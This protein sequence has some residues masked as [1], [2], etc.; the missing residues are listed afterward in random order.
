MDKLEKFFKVKESGSTVRTEIVAGITTFFAMAYIVLVAPN[1]LT[2]FSTEYQAVWNS[3][4]IAS[5]LVAV[6]GTL[7]MAFHAKMPYAQACGMGLLSV[8]SVC[9]MMPQIISGGNVEAGYQAGLVIVFLSGV[10]FLIMTVT[11]TREFVARSMPESIKKAMSAGIGLFIAFIG[12]QNVGI[13]QANPYTLTQFVDIHGA[14]VSENGVVDVMPAILALLGFILI[15]VLEKRRIKGGVMIGIVIITIVYYVFLGTVPILD[16]GQLGQSF[17]DFKDI[18]FLAILSPEAWRNAFSPEYVGGLINGIIYVF[19]FCL[20][21]MFDTVGT[22]YGVAS[23]AN[24]LDEDGDP[25][26][27]GKAMTCDSLAT[28]A[29]G[30]LGTSTASSYVE[31]SAGVAAGG[32]TGLTALVTA[33]CF[34]ACL[35]LAPLAVVI[36]ACATAPALIYVGVLMVGNIKAV[37][38][39]DIESAVPAF[40]TMIMMPLSYSIANG[41]GIGCISYV[42]IRIGTGKFNKKDLI[43]TAI[44]LL[45]VVK[46]VTIS[47]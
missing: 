44:A 47:M 40:L 24:L 31:S 12:F 19:V 41:I 30:V 21:N 9:F 5:I 3:V 10:L 23:Q 33:I 35:F 46:F 28:V 4:Y 36:P 11:G 2:G 39:S 6:V 1:Q 38:F 16:L 27:L 43:I 26:N 29:S 42:L 18:G 14:I 8:F 45:F 37:D 32:R 25:I 22:L 17:C 20:V 13:I 7:L 15:A 34:L